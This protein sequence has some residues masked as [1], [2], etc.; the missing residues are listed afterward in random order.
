MN[1]EKPESFGALL[2]RSRALLDSA[3][4]SCYE[5]QENCQNAR[6]CMNEVSKR[7][8]SMQGAIDGEE[9]KAS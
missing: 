8:S 2:T 3:Q 6:D 7:Y 5:A 9:S 1:K 4:R